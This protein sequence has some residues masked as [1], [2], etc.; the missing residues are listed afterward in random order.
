MRTA[1]PNEISTVRTANSSS[2]LWGFIGSTKWRHSFHVRMYSS[3]ADVLASTSS[4]QFVSVFAKSEIRKFQP[5]VVGIS[6]LSNIL[7]NASELITFSKSIGSVT[8]MGGPHPTI[9]P[10]QPLIENQ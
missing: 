4:F 10:E 3:A 5:K 8:I 6:V 1:T 7:K 2:L 9:D